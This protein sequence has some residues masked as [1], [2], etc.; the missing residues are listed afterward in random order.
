MLTIVEGPDGAGKTSLIDT[1]WARRAQ[2]MHH[3]PYN[4]HRDTYSRYLK[5]MI[6]RRLGAHLVYDRSWISEP[7][8]GEV[9]RN[10]VS[11][12]DGAHRRFLERLALSHR[13]V[14]VL[15]LPPLARCIAAWS[16]RLE[17]E[18]LKSSEALSRVYELYATATYTLPLVRYDYTAE[19][20]PAMI[21]QMIESIRPQPNIGPGVGH[22][23]PER[24]TLLVA[25]RHN[26]DQTDLVRKT[27][28]VLMP[29]AQTRNGCGAWFAERLEALG[30]REHDL[31]WV[32]AYDAHER[33][34]PAGFID[35][36]RPQR[37]IALGN[38]AETWCQSNRVTCT[39]IHHPQYWKRFHANEPWAALASAFNIKL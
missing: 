31:Y 6:M 5:P 35:E 36:L 24:V 23:D 4:G 37:V 39:A 11:R 38:E 16:E 3:G 13:A 1:L 12:I 21:S 9:Y 22:W 8:Y 2:V 33:Y 28:A 7:I 34:T 30:V 27:N 32:N 18:Y 20:P 25:D 10:G 19:L 15:A 14:L 26:S 17:D 29:F